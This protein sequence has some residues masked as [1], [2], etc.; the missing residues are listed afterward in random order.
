MAKQD[1][2]VQASAKH[3][4]A[5]LEDQAHK[6]SEETSA[7]KLDSHGLPLRPQPSST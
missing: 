4:I 2:G 6:A 5:H 3:D 1:S 7:L